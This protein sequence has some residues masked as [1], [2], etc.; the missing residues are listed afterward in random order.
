MKLIAGH[1]RIW[2]ELQHWAG[3]RTVMIS[4]HYSWSPGSKMQKSY[5]GLYRS[6][7]YNILRIFPSLIP[8]VFPQQWKDIIFRKL[9]VLPPQLKDLYNKLLD[10]LSPFNRDRAENLLLLRLN[11]N[12]RPVYEGSAS[13]PLSVYALSWLNALEDP[14]F[15]SVQV[16]RL[17]QNYLQRK[18]QQAEKWIPSS[19]KG[20]LETP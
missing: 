4:N 2:T 8:N 17:S 7:M 6:V 1:Q 18:A 13:Y 20:L 3:N 14:S 15:P 5:G 16:R 12:E 11:Y 19:T 10:S 9:E